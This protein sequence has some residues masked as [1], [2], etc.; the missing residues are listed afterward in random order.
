M[1]DY[2]EGGTPRRAIA[3]P[4]QGHEDGR[5]RSAHCHLGNLS[6]CSL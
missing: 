4:V 6:R 5:P 3:G 1:P 2:A